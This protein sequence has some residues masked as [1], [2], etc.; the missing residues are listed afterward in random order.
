MRHVS[1]Q[2]IRSFIA[3]ARLGQLC[4]AIV[5]VVVRCALLQHSLFSHLV[6]AFT[7]LFVIL[8]VFIE[9][10]KCYGMSLRKLRS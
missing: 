9:S 6:F 2:A 3:L 10:R 4:L 7:D 8:N 1:V 5:V